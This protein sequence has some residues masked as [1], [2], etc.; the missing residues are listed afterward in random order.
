MDKN[1]YA[2]KCV[3]CGHLN[4]P[5]RMRCRKCGKTE[6]TDFELVPLPKR[7]KL[8]T[9]TRVYNLPS[10][11]MLATLQLGMVELENGVRV[12]GQLQVANP[13]AGMPVEARVEVVRQSDYDSFYGMVFY[14]A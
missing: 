9:Y 11:Y 2:Y 7:G 6:Y 13:A 3:H 14:P 8:L 5:Y 1:I 10:D 4:Y 12:L